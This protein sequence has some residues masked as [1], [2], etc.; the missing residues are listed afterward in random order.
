MFNKN[1]FPD[2][3]TEAGYIRERHGAPPTK[4]PE[5]VAEADA[6]RREL[7]D[8]VIAAYKNGS[9]IG[10][11]S[12]HF[13]TLGLHRIRRVIATR[14]LEDKFPDRAA[15]SA[16]FGDLYTKVCKDCM[17]RY[18]TGP[19]QNWERGKRLTF[20]EPPVCSHAASSASAVPEGEAP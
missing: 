5:K 16:F 10:S 7:E 15:L 12:R 1:D 19:W 13:G 2:F 4:P 20:P 18:I 3:M 14:N 8:E 6:R 17:M 11:L 9:T